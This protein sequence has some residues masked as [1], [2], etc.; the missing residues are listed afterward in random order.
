MVIWL[1]GVLFVDDDGRSRG[2]VYPLL[3]K[4]LD[5]IAG[6]YQLIQEMHSLTT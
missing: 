6:S 4:I 3:P 2:S 5:K 1:N